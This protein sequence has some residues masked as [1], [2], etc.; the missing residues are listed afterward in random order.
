MLESIK[1]LRE[2][3]GAGMMDVKKAL[4]DAGNDETK[5]VALLRERGIVKAAKKSDREAKEGLVRFVID[6]NSAAMVE[7]NSETDFVDRK[8]VV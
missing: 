8:S 7:L 5:A 3:T 4:A 1:K 2:M 6:G